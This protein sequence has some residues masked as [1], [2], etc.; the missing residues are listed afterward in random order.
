MAGSDGTILT[1]PRRRGVPGADLSPPRGFPPPRR[2]PGF[3]P[4][5]PPISVLPLPLLPPSR[6]WRIWQGYRPS[7]H[8]ITVIILNRRL[9]ETMGRGGGYEVHAVRLDRGVWQVNGPREWR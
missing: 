2:C 3:P 5:S 1:K 9:L 8:V 4:F 6:S 7:G